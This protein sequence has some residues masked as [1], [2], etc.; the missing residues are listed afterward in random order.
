[1]ENLSG[2]RFTLGEAFS[3]SSALMYDIMTHA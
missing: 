1:M 3:S 2:Y